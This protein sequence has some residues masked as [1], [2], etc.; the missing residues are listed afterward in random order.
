MQKRPVGTIELSNIQYTNN[1][2]EATEFVTDNQGNLE[3]RNIL[4]GKYTM[5]ETSVSGDSDGLGYGE[6]GDYVIWDDDG[7]ISNGISKTIEIKRQS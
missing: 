7:N 3:I 1:K 5:E 4:T 6:D 2:D